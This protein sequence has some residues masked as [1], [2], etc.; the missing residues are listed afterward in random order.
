[1]DGLFGKA[2]MAKKWAEKVEG[3]RKYQ[4]I[5][6]WNR[7]QRGISIVYLFIEG[8]I[9][10]RRILV[11]LFVKIQF[12]NSVYFYGIITSSTLVLPIA[13]HE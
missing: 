10:R 13:L 8:R 3:E 11:C 5:N 2:R 12:W 9:F 4:K 6:G 7:K 1:M